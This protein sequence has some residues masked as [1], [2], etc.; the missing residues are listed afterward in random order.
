MLMLLRLVM[1]FLTNQCF[2]GKYQLILSKMKLFSRTRTLQIK[3]KSKKDNKSQNTH[4]LQWSVFRTFLSK[5]DFQVN[6]HPW[7]RESRDLKL[8]I[9]HPQQILISR[10]LRSSS[11]SHWFIFT[12]KNHKIIWF[13]FWCRSKN[14][15]CILK[16]GKAGRTSS[17]SA[18]SI[19]H[20]Q[21][22]AVL[23]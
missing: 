12:D 9:V 23:E 1:N 19:I 2:I 14:N 10:L 21:G 7:I 3:K 5:Q 22:D 8:W 13:L 17:H 4:L 6:V 11:W 15:F 18:L 20:P 16:S